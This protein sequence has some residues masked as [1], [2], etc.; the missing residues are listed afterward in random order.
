MPEPRRPSKQPEENGNERIFIDYPCLR[1]LCFLH[2]FL[3][4]R[5]LKAWVRQQWGEGFYRWY[6][7]IYNLIVSLTFLPI[8]ALLA[9]LPDRTLYVIPFPWSLVTGFIQ[10]L[11][12]GTIFLALLQSGLISFLGIDAF[13]SKPSSVNEK[14]V[15]TGLYAWVRHPIYT[16]G[17]VF[18]WLTPILT[19][20]LLALNI[21]L[22]LYLLVGAW[23]EERKMV[24]EFGEAYRQY[25]RR[26]P[27]LVP[28]RFPK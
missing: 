4:A 12:V 5:W 8:L 16:A 25:Q 3:A 14:L 27:M 17:L 15:V 7:L 23:L 19:R 10:L 2:S 22:T 6:R 11:A 9:W 1:I 13:F 26:V 28:Y 21:G 18:L 24:A 20:N